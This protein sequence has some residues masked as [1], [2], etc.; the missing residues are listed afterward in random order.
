M[1][2]ATVLHSNE[3]KTML[4]KGSE[5]RRLHFLKKRPELEDVL[6]QQDLS[7]RMLLLMQGRCSGHSGCGSERLALSKPLIHSPMTIL[8]GSDKV[9]EVSQA[10][11]ELSASPG[12]RVSELSISG[13][14]RRKGT[15]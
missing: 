3:L 6:V 10:A 9:K 14:K 5:Q 13:L 4:I 12:D 11:G 1:R 7:P 15:R 8:Y 2:N